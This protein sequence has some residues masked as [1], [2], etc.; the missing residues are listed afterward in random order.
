VTGRVLTAE[1]RRALRALIDQ[2]RRDALPAVCAY[3]GCEMVVNPSR[4]TQRFCSA[5]HRRYAWYRDTERGREQRRE[6]NRRRYWASK[7]S[8]GDGDQVAT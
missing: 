8:S 7:L 6:Q 1:E 3:C 2:A 4:P 5:A